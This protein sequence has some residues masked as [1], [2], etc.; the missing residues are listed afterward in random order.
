MAKV[1]TNKEFTVV[2]VSLHDGEYK[3]RYANSLKRRAV[4][5]RN[6]HTNVQL[7]EMPFAGMKEDA[8]HYLLDVLEQVNE[9]ARDAVVVEAREMGFRL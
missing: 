5:E 4:L 8:V 7:F 9:A 6:E 3:V 1:N 2:G